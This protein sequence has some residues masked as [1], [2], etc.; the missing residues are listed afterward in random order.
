MHNIW[1]VNVCIFHFFAFALVMPILCMT[2]FFLSPSS[3][4]SL[5][6][7]ARCPHL[8]L[9][10]V[11]HGISGRYMNFCVAFFLYLSCKWIYFCSIAISQKIMLML[12]VYWVLWHQPFGC[13]ISTLSTLA[14]WNRKWVIRAIILLLIIFWNCDVLFASWPHLSP[15][16]NKIVWF[17]IDHHRFDGWPIVRA[18][19]QLQTI[20]HNHKL[21]N[22]KCAYFTH[23]LTILASDAS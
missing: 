2:F 14:L 5:P 11:S 18:I 17:K 3:L 8:L 15:N 4:S 6:H 9:W 22:L 21:F 20:S 10:C 7:A 19:L 16:N 23:S 1:S 12:A 13:R